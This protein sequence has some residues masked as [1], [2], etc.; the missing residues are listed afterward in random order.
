[1]GLKWSAD[2]HVVHLNTNRTRVHSTRCTKFIRS[3]NALHLG[4]VSHYLKAARSVSHWSTHPLCLQKTGRLGWSVQLDLQHL[5]LSEAT[6]HEGK[7]E[8]LSGIH[9][10][11]INEKH[12]SFQKVHK[13][14]L[15]RKDM[16]LTTFLITSGSI[17]MRGFGCGG[18]SGRRRFPSI[19]ARQC[20]VHMTW[21]VISQPRF[22]LKP[23]CV[24]L[25]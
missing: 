3:R 22:R 18:N 10:L 16:H 8:R 23:L 12:P 14:I 24:M 5:V 1:M 20:Q 17:Q 4:I 9:R 21:L 7:H 2:T 11:P 6:N 15:K 25:M 13:E 19:W